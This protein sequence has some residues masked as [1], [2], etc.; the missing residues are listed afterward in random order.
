MLKGAKKNAFKSMFKRLLLSP[1]RY[2]VHSLTGNAPFCHGAK[3]HTRPVD[4]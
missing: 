2:T 3:R 4:Y 1:S